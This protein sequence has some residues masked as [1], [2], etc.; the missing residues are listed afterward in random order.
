MGDK[1]MNITDTNLW[2]IAIA[3][4]CL[5]DKLDAKVPPGHVEYVNKADAARVVRAAVEELR[6][7]AQG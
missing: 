4:E 7:K 1:T 6:A 5:A 3:L 2:Q